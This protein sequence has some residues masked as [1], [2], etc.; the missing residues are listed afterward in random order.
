MTLA[1]VDSGVSPPTVELSQQE[2]VASSLL[3]RRNDA[4]REAVQLCP[5]V[6]LCI[7]G[8]CWIGVGADEVR[9]R[10]RCTPALCRLDKSCDVFKL[11][12]GR[13]ANAQQRTDRLDGMMRCV[14][15]ECAAI[16]RRDCEEGSSCTEQQVWK[17]RLT[18]RH[19]WAVHAAVTELHTPPAPSGHGEHH[20]QT[21]VPN[22]GRGCS[23]PE[24]E[25]AHISFHTSNRHW[26]ISSRPC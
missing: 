16:V 19:V 17:R 1:V 25:C 3:P 24:N 15:C 9:A 2:R 11:R 7:A 20:S 4:V 18:E 22:S 6:R 26:T 5:R 21:A 12:R 14:V 8:V 13:T 10:D 23:T